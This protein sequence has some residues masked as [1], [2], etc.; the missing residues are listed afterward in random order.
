MEA[1]SG[2]RRSSR[3]IRLKT[4]LLLK[5]RF[6][7]IA[8]MSLGQTPKFM[9]IVSG[10]SSLEC[11][12]VDDFL[13]FLTFFNATIQSKRVGRFRFYVSYFEASAQWNN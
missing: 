12:E 7:T 1:F 10:V 11:G 6:V 5:T 2:K 3:V 13:F 9:A 8:V 4:L